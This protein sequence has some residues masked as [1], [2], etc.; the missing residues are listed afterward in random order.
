ML[1]R[2][3]WFQKSDSVHSNVCPNIPLDNLIQYRHYLMDM[4]PPSDRCSVSLGCALLF[5]HWMFIRR[6]TLP[7]C[8][9]PPFARSK[10]STLRMYVHISFCL[11]CPHHGHSWAEPVRSKCVSHTFT[12]AEARIQPSSS[13]SPPW[14]V[15]SRGPCLLLLLT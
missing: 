9:Y 14:V 10:P 3:H 15:L 4:H 8:C 11:Q 6:R 1:P 12:T 7:P 5:G 2:L 13:R